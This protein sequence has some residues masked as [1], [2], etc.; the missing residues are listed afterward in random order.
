[1]NRGLPGVAWSY[2]QHHEIRKVCQ[3]AV[4]RLSSGQQQVIEYV[5]LGDYSP[6]ELADRRHVKRS[7][8]YNLKNQ[9]EDRLERDDEL[10]NLVRAREGFEQSQLRSGHLQ[11]MKP[12]HQFRH[13]ASRPHLQLVRVTS[14]GSVRREA[15][16]EAGDR[17]WACAS[18]DESQCRIHCAVAQG[19]RKQFKGGLGF[20]GQRSAVAGGNTNVNDSR[21]R[22]GGSGYSESKALFD[23]TDSPRDR[24]LAGRVLD[25]SAGRRRGSLHRRRPAI[26]R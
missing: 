1:M 4:G 6:Q 19:D 7:M 25:S 3:R 24:G 5:V 10:S 21:H 15:C 16:Q 9:A 11:V 2:G 26:D 14:V 18:P 12:I 13:P 22:A 23:R 17:T 8:I 20:V